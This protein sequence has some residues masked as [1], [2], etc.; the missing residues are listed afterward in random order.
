MKNVE[1]RYPGYTTLKVARSREVEHMTMNGWQMLDVVTETSIQG[2]VG[3]EPAHYSNSA[4]YDE[5]RTVE[6]MRGHI[7]QETLFVM[8]KDDESQVAKLREEIKTKEDD[9]VT[10][11]DEKSV[12][13]AQRDE[14]KRRDEQATETRNFYK[15]ELDK[16]EKVHADDCIARVAI[17]DD[18]TK[19]RQA[20]GDTRFD[21][22]LHGEDVD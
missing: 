17:E 19:V 9:V 3:N 6:T 8:G 18:L 21:K 1:S 14:A 5:K 13:E 12:A 15:T 7:V 22:I 2:F 10:A 16:M 11:S 4:A 20:I